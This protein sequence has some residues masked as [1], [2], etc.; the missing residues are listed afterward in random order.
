MDNLRIDTGVKRI[1]INDGPEFLEFNP[2][3]ILFAEKFYSL[4]SEF[5][6][7]MDEYKARTEEIEANKEL[8]AHG[9][10][11]NFEARVKLMR[12]VCEFIRERIDHL[13]GAGTSQKAFGNVLSL[14]VFEQFFAGITPFIKQ[15]RNEKVDKYTPPPI[16][17]KR[18]N[19]AVMK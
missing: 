12:E 18:K 8:D 19:K 2:S 3:D 1:M 11:V 15:A 13:F 10:P 7:K 16:S 4:I 9:M 6:T 17:K 5:E 14:N